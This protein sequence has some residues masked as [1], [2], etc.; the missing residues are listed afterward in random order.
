[1]KIKSALERLPQDTL[2][3]TIT[4]PWQ[5][6]KKVYEKVLERKAKEIEVTGFRKGKAPLSLVKKK[7]GTDILARETLQEI[8]PAAYAEAIKEHKLKPIMQPIIK[9][10]SIIEGKDWQFEAKTCEKPQ[11]KLGKYKEKVKSSLKNPKII[12]PGEE[13]KEKEKSQ[14]EKL[15]E[16][17]EALLK[18]AKIKLP[19]ILI[20]S[21][22]NRSLALLLE[23]IEKLGI[24]LESYLNSVKKTV[25]QVRNEYQNRGE[26]A[27][28]LEFILEAIAEDLSVK[29][30]EKEI[31]EVVEKAATGKEKASI[32]R[33]YMASL[34]RRQKT[35][36][37]LLNL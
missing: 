37:K 30:E 10:L 23:Q 19:E 18:E 9:V 32:N 3:F 20:E 35:I 34:L 22:V 5:E 1:M 29:V 31:N 13:E 4:L 16:L 17:F 27:L 24:T 26:R 33:Y 8:L 15:K 36:D 14:E 7:L 21:E 12:L 6:V 11:L 28:K 25:D 2:K